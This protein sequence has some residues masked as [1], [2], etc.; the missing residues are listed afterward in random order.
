MKPEEYKNKILDE[1]GY[2]FCEKCKINNS[3]SFAVHHI[4]FR[5]EAPKHK[6][7]HNEKNLII[8]CDKCHSL[9][10]GKKREFREGIVEERGLKELFN[11]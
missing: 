2:I 5:S 11:L 4:I 3:F 9:A 7:L 6:E 10:H 1:H 8:L